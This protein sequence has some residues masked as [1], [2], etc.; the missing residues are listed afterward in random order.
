MGGTGRPLGKTFFL[1]CQRRHPELP[2][3]PTYLPNHYSGHC[4]EI[5]RKQKDERLK[6]FMIQSSLGEEAAQKAVSDAKKKWKDQKQKRPK[7][8]P[9]SKK[10]FGPAAESADFGAPSTETGPSQGDTGSQ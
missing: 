3:I 1:Q 8:G 7:F 6:T 10:P 5:Q 4:L 2:K 9:G